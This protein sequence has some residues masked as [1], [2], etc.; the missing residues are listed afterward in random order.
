VIRRVFRGRSPYGLVRYLYGEGRRNEHTEPHLIASWDG[1]RAGLEPAYAEEL[2]AHTVSKL[3]RTLAAPVAG[4]NRAPERWVYHLV[5]RNDDADRRLTDAERAQVCRSA[6]DATGIAPADDPASCR[7]VA[8]RHADEHV[9]VVAILA[10]EDGRV[11]RI[12]NDYRALAEV[13]HEYERRFGLR[14]TAGRDDNTAARRP[15]VKE[16]VAAERAGRV[17]PREV[18]RGKVKVAA[19]A[20]RDFAEFTARLARD[21]VTVWPRLSERVPG[22]LT[23]YAVSLNGWTNGAGEP[24]RFG[25]DKLAPD[26]SLPKL[27]ARWDPAGSDGAGALRAGA[28]SGAPGADTDRPQGQLTRDEADR[29]W[30]EAERIV[31]EAADRIRVEAG[32]DPDRAAYAAWAAGDT[33][34]AAA[35]GVEGERGGPLTDA[36]KAFD[37]AGPAGRATVAFLSAATAAPRCA[38]RG[39]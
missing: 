4:C 22:E 5:L 7:W 16:A 9:H 25:G 6:M 10:R 30:Q 23:G 12:W 20:S 15:G 14:S 27:R 35:A 18:L 32:T 36:A 19:G 34:A 8:V 1:D 2:G 3:A 11:P 24:V 29:V 28:Q 38:R 31:R 39:G 17:P 13:A 21:G 37:R 26:L 33:L